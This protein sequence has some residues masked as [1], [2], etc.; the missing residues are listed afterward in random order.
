VLLGEVLCLALAAVFL[1]AAGRWVDPRRTGA[2]SAA[3]LASS[4]LLFFLTAEIGTRIYQRW[5][6]NLPLLLPLDAAYDPRLGWKGR[7]FTPA[8][9]EDARPRILVVGDS[10]THGLTLED[11]SVY[12]AVLARATGARV[13]AYGGGGYGTLQEYLVVDA[14]IDDVRPDLIVVQACSNDFI[15]NDHSLERTSYINNNL[16]M[17][18]YWEGGA[19]RFRYPRP[20]GR[21]RMFATAHSRVAYALFD[22]IE[23]AQNGLV[24]RSLLPCVE[25]DFEA[26]R[27]PAEFT[28]TERITSEILALLR[29]RAGATPVALFL[30]DDREPY[31][32]A[33]R[34][35]C[36]GNGIVYLPGIRA[37]LA[38]A[39]K[40]GRDVLY[41]DRAHWS[42]EGHAVVGQALARQLRRLGYVRR[43][44]P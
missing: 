33:Y 43:T 36:A 2:R 13:W 29:R 27:R 30:A 23:R 39:G 25:C 37:S 38:V 6:E 17:R 7:R 31:R 24:S 14:M 1:V 18:P 12:P 11:A 40:Q 8:A 20:F 19:I 44:A 34:R 35:L 28:A 16:M 5:V 10:F 32:S 15:N 21:A 9:A 41:A 4:L 42:V 3:L 26:G 22:R